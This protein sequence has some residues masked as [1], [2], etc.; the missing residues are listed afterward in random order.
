MIPFGG[1]SIVFHSFAK[2]VL[3][4]KKRMRISIVSLVVILVLT[5]FPPSAF[6]QDS[7]SG[8][9]HRLTTQCAAAVRLMVEPVSLRRKTETMTMRDDLDPMSAGERS[10]AAYCMGLIRGVSA[11]LVELHKIDAS[12]AT[13]E[14]MVKIVVQY[15]KNGPDELNNPDSV[16]VTRAL[17]EA[18]PPVRLTDNG[19]RE[20][21]PAHAGKK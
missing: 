6:G 21:T 7:F 14:Q 8:S 13:L 12:E 10:E 2:Q 19:D 11:A 20:C 15:M 17:T 18:S 5:I 3:W 16:V 4:E 9:G 1:L